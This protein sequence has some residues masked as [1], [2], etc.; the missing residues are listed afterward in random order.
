MPSRTFKAISAFSALL[1][2]LASCYWQ[3]GVPTGTISF[4]VSGRPGA[5]YIDPYADTLR[6]YLMAGN[7]LVR[8]GPAEHPYW[9]ELSLSYGTASADYTSPEIP[10][11]IAY[12]VMAV[13]G[14]TLGGD[15]QPLN[16]GFRR[17]VTVTQGASTAVTLTLDMVPGV[18]PANWTE[19][20]VTGVVISDDLGYGEGYASTEHGLY[21]FYAPDGA[22]TLLDQVPGAVINSLSSGQVFDGE[23]LYFSPYLNTDEGIIPYNRSYDVLMPEWASGAGERNVMGSVCLSDPLDE[24]VR[25]PVYIRDGG[26]GGVIAP[27]YDVPGTWFD[28]DFSGYE[29]GTRIYDI[30]ATD[31]FAY[32]ATS[33]GAFR[34]PHDA[35][36]AGA[37][38][39]DVIDESRRFSVGG[40]GTRILSLATAGGYLY[41][42]TTAGVYVGVLDEVG[43][44]VFADP[45]TL[46]QGTADMSA[47][48][49][50][51]VNFY[52][53]YSSPAYHNLV[54]LISPLGVEIID[55]NLDSGAISVLP[56]LPFYAGLPSDVPSDLTQIAWFLSSEYVYLF[57]S[58][59]KGLCYYS[60]MQYHTT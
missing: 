41:A 4:S 8:I 30:A 14:E 33:A 11:G 2:L 45:A 21:A 58:G 27:V 26:M 16:H 22:P 18:T 59:K 37:T 40:S 48:M 55:H 29:G 24:N 31:N 36:H 28:V 51:V 42:G 17:G 57:I 34:I 54:A 49:M 53:D 19:D 10:A 60:V 46:I 50:R 44:A 39:G 5:R 1:L 15:F 20:N 6:V 52:D 9:D 32:V 56:A 23:S 7:D 3:A 35:L 47:R 25:I 43:S 12:T 38:A 13:V